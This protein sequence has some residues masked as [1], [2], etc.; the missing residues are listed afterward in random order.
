MSKVVKFGIIYR[1]VIILLAGMIL[2]TGC[3]ID[4]FL[5]PVRHE[6]N[7]SAIAA[8]AITAYLE[9]EQKLVENFRIGSRNLFFIELKVPWWKFGRPSPQLIERL[10][11]RFRQNFMIEPV[12]SVIWED[13]LDNNIVIDRG[14]T[15]PRTGRAGEIL[16]ITA[17]RW[18]DRCRAEV[19]LRVWSGAL[20]QTNYT[21]VAVLRNGCWSVTNFQLLTSD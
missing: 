13:I 5:F 1:W 10:Q 12:Q 16:T 19:Q 3:S 9:R 20:N 15:D 6:R 4:V 17:I 2:F 8:A 21:A 14:P 18:H 11:L 7:K